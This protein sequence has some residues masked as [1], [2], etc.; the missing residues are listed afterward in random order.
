MN[1]RKGIILAGGSG[2]R[3][4]PITQAVSRLPVYDRPYIQTIEKRQGRKIVCPEEVAYRRGFIDAARE[5]LAQPLMK[6]RYGRY[7]MGVLHDRVF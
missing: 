3:L 4:Y 6:N 7:L 5:A 1:S 2:T